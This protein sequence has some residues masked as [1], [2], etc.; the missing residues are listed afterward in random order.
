[1]AL[2]STN[3]SAR[4]CFFGSSDFRAAIEVVYTKQVVEIEGYTPLPRTRSDFLGLIYIQG[5][6]VPLLD[7]YELFTRTG[8]GTPAASSVD[9]SA[10]SKAV[11]IHHQQYE[12]ALATERVLGFVGLPKD[13]TPAKV[14]SVLKRFVIGQVPFDDQQTALL[15]NVPE[16]VS[17]LSQRLEVV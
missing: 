8:G 11:I 17:T 3:L 7:V 14:P 16:L 4:A 5:R 2:A 6:I 12:F 13:I 9:A 10:L 15:I 1:M